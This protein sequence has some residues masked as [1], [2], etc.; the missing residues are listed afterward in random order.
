MYKPQRPTASYEPLAELGKLAAQQKLNGKRHNGPLPNANTPDGKPF[1][2][3][4]G[5]LYF[6]S[7]SGQIHRVE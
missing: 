2:G 7:H 6:R 5:K 1:V 4:D 3:P